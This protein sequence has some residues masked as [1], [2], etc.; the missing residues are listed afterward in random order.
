MIK[1]MTDRIK[2]S[3]VR[4]KLKIES[5][6]SATYNHSGL[7]P[8]IA[9]DSVPGSPMVP[10]PGG[11]KMPRDLLSQLDRAAISQ[12]KS[13]QTIIRESLRAYLQSD[14]AAE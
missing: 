4:R 13:R 6:D 5:R 12:G 3:Y 1:K 14:R 10:M 11:L 2:R 9:P 7:A 8:V